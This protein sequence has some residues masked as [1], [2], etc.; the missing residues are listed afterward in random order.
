MTNLRTLPP[1]GPE[2]AAPAAR[3]PVLLLRPAFR[4]A[5]EMGFKDVKVLFVAKNLQHDWI[6]KDLP[7]Q[8]RDQ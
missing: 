3:R 7:V 1:R 2:L 6:D 8:E 4:T 5:R